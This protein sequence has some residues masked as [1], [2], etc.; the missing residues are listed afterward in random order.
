MGVLA[1]M[2]GTES[3]SGSPE[4]ERTGQTGPGARC[5]LVPSLTAV[6]DDPYDASPPEGCPPSPPWE[7]AA[8]ADALSCFEFCF[9]IDA[10]SPCTHRG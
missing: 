7:A 10:F 6:G 3:G 5:A 8:A 9:A 2:G 1:T 4:R